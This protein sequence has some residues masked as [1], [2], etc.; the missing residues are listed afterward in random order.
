MV[1]RKYYHIRI[2]VMQLTRPDWD[3]QLLLAIDGT[4]MS[5]TVFI[6]FSNHDTSNIP[7]LLNPKVNLSLEYQTKC[8]NIFSDPESDHIFSHFLGTYLVYIFFLIVCDNY[9]LNS[10][11]GRCMNLLSIDY[12]LNIIN[13]ITN[14]TLLKNAE[15]GYRTKL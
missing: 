5:S 8:D 6:N 15:H 7:N 9:P 2:F 12:Q 4:K 13:L 3:Q 11:M 1:L 10:K 14:I